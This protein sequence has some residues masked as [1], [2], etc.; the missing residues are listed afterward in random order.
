MLSSYHGHEESQEQRIKERFTFNFET[1]NKTKLYDL[2][3]KTQKLIIR[4][5]DVQNKCEKIKLLCYYM[6]T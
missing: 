6:Q 1:R 3:T 5:Q 2:E 4:T